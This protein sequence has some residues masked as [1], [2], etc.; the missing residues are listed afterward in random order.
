MGTLAS[1][2]GKADQLDRGQGRRDGDFVIVDAREEADGDA[3]GDAAQD[4]GAQTDGSG[5]SC[6]PTGIA[7]STC[8][9]MANAGCAAGACYIAGAAGMICVCPAGTAGPAASCQTTRECQPKHVCVGSQPP[10]RCRL[11]C[12]PQ[13]PQC[14]DD[15]M[16]CVEI[17][18]F[19]EYGS[20]Q[21]P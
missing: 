5:A 2:A 6:S 17:A 9:P 8:D 10:G 13:A 14:P 11:L 4:A 12:D 18:V 20:C 19:P 16:E 7:S 1:C 21:A 3:S 15:T